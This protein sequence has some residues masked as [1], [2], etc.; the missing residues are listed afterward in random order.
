MKTLKS[1][2]L[3]I[4]QYIRKW[5]ILPLDVPTAY[6]H[7]SCI[8][9]ALGIPSFKTTVPG[10]LNARLESL[11]NSTS[12]SARAIHQHSWV[13][14]KLIWSEKVLN[15]DGEV[16]LTPTS[17]SQYWTKRL[18]E[19]VD[20]K[21][22]KESGNASVSNTWIDS[23]SYGIPG[24]DYIQYHHVH[25]NA[26][27]TRVRTSRGRRTNDQQMLCRAGCRSTETGYHV[28]QQCHRTHGGRILRHNAVYKIIANSLR[29]RGWDVMV[30]KKIKGQT[31][32]CYQPDM[33]ISKDNKYYVIDSQVVGCYK[34]L[35]LLYREKSD[36]YNRR[37]L[38]K[39]L[40]LATIDINF[41]SVTISWQGVWAI[42]SVN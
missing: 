22:L 40:D 38:K 11:A 42:Q 9:G 8:K 37:D 36:I 5:L 17:R 28:I 10:L 19:S 32:T 39:E 15:L 30:E 35:N 14:K 20:C 23:N 24:K 6:F 27:P 1:L 33:I 12:E 18:Y 4:R 16:R 25:I 7:A 13:V 2:D 26:L 41:S 31:G 3:K 29:Q 34:P 21:E